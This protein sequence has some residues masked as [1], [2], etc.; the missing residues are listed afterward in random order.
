MKKFFLSLSVLL[1]AVGAWAQQSSGGSDALVIGVL[2]GPTG[3]GLVKLVDESAKLPDGTPVVYRIVPSVDI[4]LSKLTTGEVDIAALPTNTAAKLYNGGMGYCLAAVIGNG[5]LSY[6]SSDTSVTS[7]MGL[8]G[9]E[10]AISGQG[11]VPEYVFRLILRKAKLNPDSDVRLN[12]SLPYPEAVASL[13]AGKIQD[14]VLPEPF[15]TMALIGN[16]KLRV[17]FDIQA[18]YGAAGG[19]ATYPL[20][21][22]VVKKDLFAKR[23][24]LV[25]A[26]LESAKASI[27]WTLANPA[28]AGAIV[29]RLEFGMKAKVAEASI[30]K[31]NY[32]FLTAKEAKKDIESL[33]AVL[34]AENPVSIGGKLPD[35]AFYGF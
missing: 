26:F 35:A 21:V 2:K 13:V 29:E 19:S 15:A 7:V 27:A 16:P 30:P 17:P 22:L 9:R 14:A 6:I 3:V 11:A 33:F 12:F 28:Q 10:I 24:E 18:L 23:P 8:K 20:S 34:L 1:C 31:T 5:M 25:K 32:V 4:M